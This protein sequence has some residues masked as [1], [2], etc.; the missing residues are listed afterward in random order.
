MAAFAQ[1]TC[2][3][4]GVV[5]VFLTTC[6]LA[7]PQITANGLFITGQE[8]SLAC[9]ITT[10]ETVS[11]FP[12]TWSRGGSSLAASEEKTVIVSG[13]VRNYNSFYKF[14]VQPSDNEDTFTCT[15]N[16]PSGTTTASWTVYVYKGPD[17]P[18]VTGPSTVVS[19]VPSTWTCV[20]D[21]ASGTASNVYWQ[22]GNGSRL[23]FGTFNNVGAVYRDTNNLEIHNTTST[24]SL[25]VSTG[26]PNF[27]LS[28]YAVHFDTSIQKMTSRSI[29]VT[30]PPVVAGGN[31]TVTVT[32]GATY[33]ITCAADASPAIT[34]ITWFKDGVQ[35]SIPSGRYSG[36]TPSTPD[37]TVTNVVKEDSGA[38][39]CSA[40]NGIGTANGSVNTLII[41]Y[42]PVV[43]SSENP[44]GGV[45]GGDVAV[46]CVI[47][48]YPAPTTVRWYSVNINTGGETEII[49]V[50]SAG[51]YS[52]GNATAPGLTIRNLANSDAGYYR[53]KVD[54]DVGRGEGPNVQVQVNYAPRFNVTRTQYDVNLGSVLILP[55]DYDA[56]PSPT[57]LVWL[58]NSVPLSLPSEQG[59][60]T[61]GSV[62]SPSL[63]IQNVNKTDAAVYV[64]RVTSV[65]DTTSTPNITVGV[66]YGPD[67][68]IPITVYT[69]RISSNVTLTCYVD[70]YPMEDLFVYWLKDGQP[71]NLD[72]PDREK[73]RGSLV[74]IPSLTIHD[75]TASDS[76]NYTCRAGSPERIVSGEAVRLD[77]SYVPIMTVIAT[78]Y[79]QNAGQSQTIPCSYDAFPIPTRVQWTKNSQPLDVI[80]SGGKYAGSTT[81]NATLTINSLTREDAGTYVCTAT[82]TMGTGSSQAVT[83]SVNYPPQFNSTTPQE[84]ERTKGETVILFC[85]FNSRPPATS[86]TWYKNGEQLTIAGRYSGGNVTSPDLTITGLTGSDS[87]VYNCSVTNDIWTI[88]N[89]GTELDVF[90]PPEMVTNTTA[91][92]GSESTPVFIPCAYD[93]NPPPSQIT[94]TKDGVAIN[95]NSAAYTGGT[96]GTGGLTIAD[97]EPSDAGVY[98][99]IVVNE[100]GTNRS[101]DINVA[102]TYV[103][104]VDVGN[105]NFVTTM[106]NTTVLLPCSYEGFPAVTS[107]TW[108]RNGV[109]IDT[110]NSATYSGGVLNN[111]T[112]IIRTVQTSDDGVYRCRAT[113][114]I[115]TGESNNV[116]LSVTYLPKVVI[117]GTTY[118]GQAT[119]SLTLPCY[120]TARPPATRI[121]WTKNSQIID[122]INSGGKYQGSNLTF[123]G[124]R[125]NPLTVDDAGIYVCSAVSSAGRGSSHDA[126]VVITYVPQ[127]N[128]T[129][130]IEVN[131][132][133]GETVTLQCQADSNPPPTSI[134]WHK[135]GQQVTIMGRYSGGT[136]T[137]PA[138]TITGLTGSDSGHYNCRVTNDL[139]TGNS[140]QTNLIVQ[141]P[142][143]IVSNTTALR[144]NETT[145]IT[146]PCTY[147]ANPLPTR[148]TWTKNGATVDVTSAEYS[149]GTVGTPGL[150]IVTL[151]TTDAGVY[152]CSVENTRGSAESGDIPLNVTYPPKID[153]GTPSEISVNES[154]SI[155]VP[156]SIDAVPP[157]TSIEWLRNGNILDVSNTAKYSGGTVPTPPLTINNLQSSDFGVYQC[158]ASNGVG[159][160]ESKN[161]TVNVRYTPIM[162]VPSTSYTRN[163][164]Q[165]L[166]ID[167]S[168]DANPQPTVIRWTKNSQPIDVSGSGGKYSGSMLA[169]PSLTINTL[170]S[171]DDGVY[172]CLAEN[173]M[174]TGQSDNV[175][176]TVNYLPTF[177]NTN[178]TEITPN[179]GSTVTITCQ[180]KA[181]PPPTSITWYKDDVPL[182]ITGRYSGGTLSNPDL[183]I[184]NLNGSESGSYYCGITNGLGSRNNTPTDV[185]VQYP[186]EIT[187]NT[188]EVVGRESNTVFIPCSYDANPSP[189]LITWTKDDVLLDINSSRYSGGMPGTGGLT[190]LNLTP[191]D[192]GAYQCTVGNSKGNGSSGEV[193]VT[194]TYPPKINSS[195]TDIVTGVQS[196][197]LTLFCSIR[198][199]PPVTSVLWFRDGSVMDLRNS[200]KYS[201][202]TVDTPNL[203]IL[204]LSSSDA[205]VYMCRATNNIGTTD[206]ENVTAT[207][208]YRPQISVQPSVNSTEPNQ[209]TLS[210]IV[211]ALPAVTS[212]TWYKDGGILNTSDITR[213]SG[214]TTT[215]PSL[216]IFAAGAADAGSYYCVASNS[217]GS[218]TGGSI[219]LNV[220]YQP[221]ITV[222]NPQIGGTLGGSATLALTVAANPALTFIQWRKRGNGINV[223]SDINVT[224]NGKYSGGTLANPSLQINSLNASDIGNYTLVA[225]NALGEAQS[226]DFVVAVSYSPTTPTIANLESNYK[227][228]DPISLTCSSSGFPQPLYRWY[229]GS[230]QIS[231]AA[232][233]NIANATPSD[234][235]NFKCE[236]YN[237][238]GTADTTASVNVQYKPRAAAS[239]SNVTASVD[240]TVN[241]MCATEANPAPTSYAWTYNGQALTSA[242][243][244]LTVTVTNT[245][246]F[247]GY[248]CLATNI[249]GT[250]DPILVFIN[251]EAGTGG[252]RTGQSTDGSSG[253]PIATLVLII[254]ICLIILIVIILLCIYCCTSRRCFKKDNNVTPQVA[255]PVVVPYTVRTS[256]KPNGVAAGAPIANGRIDLAEDKSPNGMAPDSHSY[257]LLISVPG[258]GTPRPHHL[259]PL[260]EEGVAQETES[261]RED[262]PK[263][264]KKRKKRRHHDEE[265][266]GGSPSRYH[267][268]DNDAV[269][270]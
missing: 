117:N 195:T 213:Y 104:K 35:I 130:P 146:I 82:N 127:F 175:T 40:S 101:G 214:G 161:T 11:N 75:V 232:T 202:G 246:D 36:G 206:G 242:S 52:G 5:L 176:V 184:A 9:Y 99:C 136:L 118:T 56:S 12:L 250:S 252:G 140:T 65:M 105:S 61:G 10:A 54:N 145:S 236:A 226:V 92:T 133:K 251:E 165:S 18:V 158:R 122:V 221:K 124:L 249:Q 62:S 218:T 268:Y 153:T 71:V 58:K 256:A 178:P 168:Y 196:Q 260:G 28:C 155:T 37:L 93:A 174:G 162:R 194:V 243:R 216:T 173:T 137:N 129:T 154:S 42:R 142:P 219:A 98:E 110:N 59:R 179:K 125:I 234:N 265:E 239:V 241:L 169:I 25:T 148:I 23:D 230:T 157:V 83:L 2:T 33:T 261:A 223:Y 247:G 63:V 149:G 217:I 15:A 88:T 3:F 115:G 39:V 19:G 203:T 128:N 123:P 131:K 13:N 147:D 259:P 7:Q 96:H 228:R 21:G 238:L 205:G 85:Q 108:S 248:Q 74:S 267:G 76:G 152:E 199:I 132:T 126:T 190:I 43:T 138:L 31:V 4:V 237:S 189:S 109:V 229:R 113:N 263:K 215:T 55:C 91:I 257:G 185:D 90:Y 188:T 79:T 233:L 244:Q 16:F 95:I 191:N 30:Y 116:T 186:P 150:T 44:V 14:T 212:L 100:K 81:T 70:A 20:V 53:C 69:A 66:I 192:A 180:A 121:E 156:C 200:L 177:N 255:A 51:K 87:G 72:T 48:A 32:A 57:S 97:I 269:E 266:G 50:N 112:L 8:K 187:P 6:V 60:L 245:S 80:N 64:C 227:E 49:P 201:G 67:I 26:A 119:G 253:L 103:P 46:S 193:P 73:Y 120:Y 89:N 220:Q 141:Y 208:N 143:E 159:S 102:V 172:V 151:A 166:T 139:G 167:C 160:S 68:T 224:S 29:T 171:A 183:I 86:I 38:Y 47:D 222:P 163:A 204:N 22:F 264:K 235:T 94:W 209:A 27:G 134:T 106:E 45:L 41:R 262:K 211:N 77:V 107:L 225:T 181:N 240:Q 24:L 182:S 111:P 170:G 144:G 254:I 114:R 34:S 197:S 1:R 258:G 198:A 78:A 17:D 270:A 210:C 135:N 164:S 84:V 207:V 231:D